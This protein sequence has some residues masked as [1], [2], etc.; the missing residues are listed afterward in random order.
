MKESR[1][2]EQDSALL[3]AREFAKVLG[4][5]VSTLSRLIGSGH[6][7]PPFKLCGRLK[8]VRQPTFE[9]INAGCPKVEA[10]PCPQ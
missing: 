6:V 7:P 10:K 1:E 5:S 3:G 9:W 2:F 4:C 8:W